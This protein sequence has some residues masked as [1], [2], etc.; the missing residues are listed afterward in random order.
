VAGN[1][2]LNV[3][4]TMLLSPAPALQPTLRGRV[5]RGPQLGVYQDL[6][7]TLG[8]MACELTKY[9]Y[10]LFAPDDAA[11]YYALASDW[12][13]IISIIITNILIVGIVIVEPI[14]RTL[15]VVRYSSKLGTLT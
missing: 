3:V 10:T 13:G 6:L 14:R 15:Y 8:L 12:Q 4:D 7:E 5:E 9:S 11:F 1:G 2:V